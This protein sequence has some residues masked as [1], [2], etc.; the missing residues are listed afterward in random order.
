MEYTNYA[1]HNAEPVDGFILQA[2]VSD[3][4][5][6]DIVA[7][8]W[9]ESLAK[10]NAMIAEGKADWAMPKDKVPNVLGAPISAYRLQ[11]LV[12]KEY[13]CPET[14]KSRLQSYSN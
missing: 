4:E 3:R 1:K 6:L 8:N 12:A 5:G 11:S 10:A 7:P 13:E 14:R 9:R 2:P